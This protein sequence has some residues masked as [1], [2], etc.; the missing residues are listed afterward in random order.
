MYCIL[1]LILFK[2]FF[3]AIYQTMPFE[4][5]DLCL[6]TSTEYTR[7]P[8]VK[9]I[10][11]LSVFKENYFYDSSGGSREYWMLYMYR[12]RLSYGRIMEEH[13]ATERIYFT[14]FTFYQNE[15]GS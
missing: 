11:Y 5:K 8:L 14:Y 10:L 12:A 7:F 1:M 9:K 13:G 6:Q 3:P 2:I 4:V 15:T